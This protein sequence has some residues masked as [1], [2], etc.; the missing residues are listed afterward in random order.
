V[1]KD[2]WTGFSTETHIKTLDWNMVLGHGTG[3]WYW[4]MVLEHGT[5]TW[6]CTG[7]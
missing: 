1:S 5:G 7:L 3:T 6:D 4:N 2:R